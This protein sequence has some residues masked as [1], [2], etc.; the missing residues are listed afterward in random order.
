MTTRGFG[1]SSARWM[2]MTLVL[3][4]HGMAHAQAAD[5][6]FASRNKNAFGVVKRLDSGDVS[7]VMTLEDDRGREFTEPGN[8]DLCFQKPSLL[9]RRV[10]LTYGVA[11]VLAAECQ[12]DVDCRKSE[13]VALV[14]KA[15]IVESRADSNAA[16]PTPSG[17]A[18]FCA[19]QEE[20][21]FACRTGAKLASICASRDASATRGYVQYRF[22]KP[23]SRQSLE[24]ALP[25]DRPAPPKAATGESVAFSGG[26]GAWMRFRKGGFA[27][28]AYTGIGRWG[29]NGETREKAGIVVEQAGKAIATLKC[30]GRPVSL[31]GPAWFEKAGVR[32]GGEEF[33]FPD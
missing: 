3:A 14:T 12:G 26:G 27:Y 18:S 8:F 32:G 16:S 21:V 15:R 17:Q 9:G 25:E 24:L 33:D 19:P 1:M 23:D 2:A 22:G 31:L 10:A 29:P 4:A 6:A 5:Q 20:V 11:N 13:R 30:S 7:C 28:V